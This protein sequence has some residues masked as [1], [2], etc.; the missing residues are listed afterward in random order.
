[1]LSASPSSV[2]P[3]TPVTASWS[4]ITGPTA[5]DWVGLYDSSTAVNPALLNWA[6]TNGSAAG[7]LNLSVPSGTTPGASY[8][9]RLL[10]NNSYTR[11]ATSAPFSV[12][13]STA[14]VSPNPTAVN[15]G[16]IVAATW[17]GI[18][19]P[20]ATDWVGL[21][22]SSSA[23]DPA[24]LA[25]A[26]TSG[27]AAGSVDLT[28]PPG[29]GSTY[30][31]RLFTANSYVRL[32]TSAPFSVVANATLSASPSSVAAGSPVTVT[33]SG[34]TTPTATDWLGLY[35]TSATAD[36][37]WWPGPT[38]EERPPAAST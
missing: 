37:A 38:P 7:S 19:A 14:T 3:G 11:L 27:S 32:A 34:I 17:A 16:G 9:L 6:Y 15:P 12:V 18:A 8:E 13:A 23:L 29:A 21:Y 10:T 31:L 5:T 26:Y 4:G 36:P 30:E 24:L 22:D 35:P 2:N 20:T 25:W 28:V 33:W 1:M